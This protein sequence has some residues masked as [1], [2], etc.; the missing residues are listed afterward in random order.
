MSIAVRVTIDDKGASDIIAKA[1]NNLPKE[2]SNSAFEYSKLMAKALRQGAVNDPLRPTTPNRQSAALRINARRLTKDKSVVIM[3]SSL[4]MLDGMKP[5][6]V[7]LKRGR[8]INRWARKNFGNATV[9]GKSKVGR[10]PR[11][12]IL[13]HYYDD[14]GVKRRSALFVTPHHFIQATI[15][16]ERNKLPNKLRQGINKAFTSKAF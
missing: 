16:R 4:I 14:Q 3:P 9:S 2:I 5:H 12:G 13:E 7:S 11:G 8:S 6:Y 10:G 15:A 1:T